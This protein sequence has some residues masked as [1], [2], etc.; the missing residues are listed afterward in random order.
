[1]ALIRCG[2]LPF[3][4]GD[5]INEG[6]RRDELVGSATGGHQVRRIT[7]EDVVSRRTFEFLTNVNESAVA[8]G[9]LVM[10]YRMRWGIEKSFDEIKNKLGEKKAWASS[11]CAKSMQAQFICLGMN[12]LALFEHALAGQGIRNEPEERRR[13]GRLLKEQAHARSLGKVLP[14]TIAMTQRITQ[15]SVKFIRWVAAQLWLNDSWKTA[16]AA[17]VALYARL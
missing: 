7:F 6:V 10:L 15:R 14:A 11:A 17:L 4:R 9:L 5:P 12:L 8:P 1:M 16:C 2:D 13:A 3:E